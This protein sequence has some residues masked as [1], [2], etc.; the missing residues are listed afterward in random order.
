MLPNS[1]TNKRTIHISASRS[2]KRN[3]AAP[4]N[5]DDQPIVERMTRK[6]LAALGKLSPANAAAWKQESI[7][8]PSWLQLR[9]TTRIASRST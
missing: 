1:N 5:P 3:I 6:R 4:A 8:T 2:H 7:A 9:P